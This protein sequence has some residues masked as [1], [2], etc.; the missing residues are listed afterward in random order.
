MEIAARLL[1]TELTVQGELSLATP[2]AA[3]AVIGES[4]RPDYPAANP[5]FEAALRTSQLLAGSGQTERTLD[6]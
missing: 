2:T 6:E 3:P 1:P 5:D 4:L